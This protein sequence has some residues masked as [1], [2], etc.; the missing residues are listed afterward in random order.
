MTGY[1]KGREGERG[2][3]RGRGRGEGFREGERGP[4][5]KKCDGPQAVNYRWP[6]FDS[7]PSKEVRVKPLPSLST[8]W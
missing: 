3:G 5:T 6:V 8:H 1:G 2:R 7:E 4:C